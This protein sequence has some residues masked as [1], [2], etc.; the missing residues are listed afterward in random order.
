MFDLVGQSP[1]GT[2]VAVAIEGTGRRTL[3]AFLTSGCTTCQA[4]WDSMRQPG[5]ELPPE[6]DRVVVVTHSQQQESPALI[7]RLAPPGSAG[8]TVV[9]ADEPWETYRVPATPYFVLADGATNTIVGEGA[10]K[11]WPQLLGLLRR[12]VADSEPIEDE[13]SVIDLAAAEG[14]RAGS[15]AGSGSRRWP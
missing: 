11:G 8:V 10:A 14:E 13:T 15:A 7:G 12:A 9:M 3:L 4:F 5:F 6:V 1:H 2:A